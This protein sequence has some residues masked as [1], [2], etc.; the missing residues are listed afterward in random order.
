M[1]ISLI[2]PSLNAAT[3]ARAL[4]ALKEQTRP[5][6][7]II[8]VGRDEA[9]VLA[10]FPQIIFVDSG[11]PVCAARAR[12]LGMERA[13]GD[14]FLFL[15][16]DC[17]PA[18]DWV[19]IHAQRQ[20]QGQLVVGGGVALQGSNYWAQSDN[21]SMFHE[22]VPQHPAG[23]RA[24]LPT[25]NLSVR[26]SAVEQVG[27]LDESFPGAAAEDTD[28][29]I[30]L[31]Q[32]GYRLYFE[33]GAI[34]HHA[35]VRTTWAD[36]VRHWRNLGHN[37]IRVRHRYPDEFGTPRLAG[38]SRWLRLLSPLIAVRVTLGIYARP[39]FWRYWRCLPVVYVT[40]II[41]CLGAADAVD[42]GFAF[43]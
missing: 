22:F 13:Q 9:G 35:P 5:P 19:A 28:W 31:R 27:G 43:Q 11:V 29:T 24:F 34:V 26:R 39:I 16:A 18:P 4:N 8:V 32:S 15:D 30:R 17:I 41:Y 25:L 38:R 12:N 1:K 20:E 14:V 10:A 23:Y 2:I 36:V 7:E 40:K 42:S 6:D 3:L 37:A 21:I 33:P